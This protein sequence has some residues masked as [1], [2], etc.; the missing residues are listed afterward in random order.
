MSENK[1][2]TI[3]LRTDEERIAWASAKKI[4]FV[5]FKKIF[6]GTSRGIERLPMYR[7]KIKTHPKGFNFGR[8]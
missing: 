8:F 2:E 1:H 6:G 4:A 5:R 7:L 3:F